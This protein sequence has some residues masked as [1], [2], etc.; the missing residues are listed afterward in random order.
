MIAVDLPEYRQNQILKMWY[1]SAKSAQ[2]IAEE[3]AVTP[4][5]VFAVV[6]NARFTKKAEPHN[7]RYNQ[8]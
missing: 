6:D 5:Q 8:H 4:A 7:E 1:G 2:A 3:L